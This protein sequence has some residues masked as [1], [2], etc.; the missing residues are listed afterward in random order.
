ML[1]V[2]AVALHVPMYKLT[3]LRTVK[4]TSV[5]KPKRSNHID[6]KEAL[7]DENVSSSLVQIMDAIPLLSKLLRLKATLVHLLL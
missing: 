7:H 4:E 3:H 1:E 2:L 5:P 6:I